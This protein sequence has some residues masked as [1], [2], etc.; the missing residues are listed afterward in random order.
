[1]AS[2]P[3]NG[4][5]GLRG[6]NGEPGLVTGIVVPT[7]LQMAADVVNYFASMTCLYNRYWYAEQGRITLP[8]AL[9]HVTGITETWQNEVSKKR[10]IMYEPSSAPPDG[11]ELSDALRSGV[12]QVF[13]DNVV[14]QPKSYQM[15]VI[16]PFQPV[17]RYIT[18]GFDTALGIFNGIFEFFEENKAADAVRSAFSGV[19]AGLDMIKPIIDIAGKLPDTDGVSTINKNSLE[20]MAES[21][22][23]LTMKMWTGYHYKY[24]VITGLSIT[25]RPNEDSVFRGTIQLQ[26]LPV[27][28]MTKPSTRKVSAVDRDWAAKGV[29]GKITKG[30]L[31]MQSMIV[32]PLIQHLGVAAASG[33]TDDLTGAV[34][35]AAGL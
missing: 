34:K 22:K 7:I 11:K 6:P 35:D 28:T 20:A 30:S 12:M 16:I 24:A 25:K 21:G 27:L 14:T 33:Q 1:M 2:G 9:F 10:V 13:M 23:I 17:G 15:E 19:R 5:Q 4:A 29:L 32:A 8:I 26:E 3:V 18:D 31:G